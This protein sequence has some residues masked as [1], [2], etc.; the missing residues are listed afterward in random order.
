MRAAL[1]AVRAGSRDTGR[2]RRAIRSTSTQLRAN[3]RVRPHL[4]RRRRSMLADA[5]S[6]VSDATS[7]RRSRCSRGLSASSDGGSSELEKQRVGLEPLVVVDMEQ[8]TDRAKQRVFGGPGRRGR[9]GPPLAHL[10]P[11]VIAG[12]DVL[13]LETAALEVLAEA[14]VAERPK[15]ARSARATCSGSRRGCCAARCR[16]PPDRAPSCSRRAGTGSPVSDL[17]LDVGA[18]TAEQ[19]AKRRSKRNSLRC[20]ADE[21]EDGARA[22]ARRLAQAAARAAAGTAS[23]SRSAAASAA[24]RRSGRRCLR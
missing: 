21:V 3:L 13:E 4:A 20:D 19:R 23:G 17:P 14:D 16:A 9:R 7:M 6:L 12:V 15:L 22:L 1:P 11:A 24:C 5:L 2:A 8:P 10:R 18:R